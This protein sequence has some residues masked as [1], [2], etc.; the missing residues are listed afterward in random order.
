[1]ELYSQHPLQFPPEDLQI[2]HGPAV[3][4]QVENLVDA[5]GVEHQRGLFFGQG[6]AETI[7]ELIAMERL[8][9]P[10]SSSL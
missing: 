5:I 4:F 10:P 2:H 7:P 8:L 6:F 1:M 3:L 9:M